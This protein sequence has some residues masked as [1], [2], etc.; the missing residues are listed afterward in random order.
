MDGCGMG[1]RAPRDLRPGRATDKRLLNRGDG[2]PVILGSQGTGRQ[3]LH[4]VD[5]G[6][7]EVLQ[8]EAVVE[9]ALSRVQVGLSEVVTG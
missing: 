5:D 1:L 2:V 7:G 6:G 8:G 4:K 3:G 9:G